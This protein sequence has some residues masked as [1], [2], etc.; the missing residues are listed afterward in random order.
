MLIYWCVS[1]FY[2]LLNNTNCDIWYPAPN[3]RHCFKI[4]IQALKIRIHALKIRIQALKIR[5]Q[6]LKIRIQ[7]FKIRIQALKIRI[8]AFKIRIQAFK[9]LRATMLSNENYTLFAMQ[10]G[11]QHEERNLILHRHIPLIDVEGPHF[12]PE[13]KHTPRK[14]L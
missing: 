11:M 13:A 9:F 8:Q 1:L 10:Q 6:A 2:L 7:A 5:I 3:V 12:L 4:R 14:Q